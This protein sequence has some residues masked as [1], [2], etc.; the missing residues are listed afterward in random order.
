MY[1]LGDSKKAVQEAFNGVHKIEI[2]F[3]EKVK[4][5][6]PTV[7]I[8]N[9][10][11]E[12]KVKRKYVRK[13]KVVEPE[14]EQEQEEETETTDASLEVSDAEEE[15]EEESQAEEEEEEED[16]EDLDSKIKELQKRKQEKELRKNLPELRN[17]LLDYLQSR[18]EEIQTQIQQVKAGECDEDLIAK[19]LNKKVKK[20]GATKSAGVAGEGGN[21]TRH[22]KNLNNGKGLDKLSAFTKKIG[23]YK[24]GLFGK[25]DLLV[26]I[27]KD[28]KYELPVWSNITNYT[29]KENSFAKVKDLKAWIKAN[30]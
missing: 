1:A 24:W 28:G 10:E 8:M 21:R 4:S 18:L 19:K 14:Q 26:V 15:E 16:D 7:A 22:T 20:D 30:K 27:D 25:E 13:P 17:E 5:I 3:Q 9:N 11:T 29:T 2:P 12:I 6:S 23:E